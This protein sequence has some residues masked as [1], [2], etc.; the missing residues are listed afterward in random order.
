M[1][2]GTRNQANRPPTNDNVLA[3]PTSTASQY[4]ENARLAA[5]RRMRRLATGLLVLM[6]AVFVAARLYEP[7]YPALGFVRA[8]A[9]A[10][11]V[12]GLADWFAV[13]AL[14]RHPLGLKI[15]HTAIVPTRKDEIG[16]Y[17]GEFI[18]TNFLVDEVISERL[19]N[20]NVARTLAGWLS[21]PENSRQIAGHLAV[22]LGAIAQAMNDADIQALIEENVSTRVRRA[23]LAPLAG[24]I[25]YWFS[26][27]E[28]RQNLL[29]ASL[30][31][32]EH[33]VQENKQLIREQISHQTPPFTP[34][35]VNYAIY[36]WLVH[37][38]TDTRRQV[39][40][41]PQHPLHQKFD[42]LVDQLVDTLKNSPDI[43]AQEAALKEELLAHPAVREFSAS[44]WADLKAAL[45]NQAAGEESEIQHTLQRGLS[46]FGQTLLSDDLLLA[47]INRWIDEI[48]RYFLH[49]YGDE[50]AR[51]IEDTIA[52]WDAQEASRKI[53]SY[54]G[55]DLQYIRINGTLV[56]GI[57]GLVIYTV[58]LW[59]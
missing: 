37:A 52:R 3:V 46:H 5:Y 38:V 8:F 13:T 42:E 24:S 21:Q 39:E 56:G 26:G 14:F 7:V 34:R 50:A 27:G 16:R 36:R 28:R 2:P 17:L 30:R 15:P 47:K 40:K 9:E 29:V 23:R 25:L 55:K 22:G 11:L 10:A 35:A 12:G 58:S 51:L 59:L 45:V 18:Q 20:I 19:A 49:A 6:T 4:A 31:L 32:V 54:V 57:V 41:D 48:V 44:L 33:L 43:E 1:A 53:E